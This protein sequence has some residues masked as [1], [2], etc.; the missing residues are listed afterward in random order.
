MNE[1][2]E[3]ILK[4]V[5]LFIDNIN[6]STKSTSKSLDN[7]CLKIDSV[8][9]K[10]NTPPRNEELSTQLG[11]LKTQLDGFNINLT[12]LIDM[13]KKMILVVRT[14][15]II[16]SLAVMLTGGIIEYNKYLEKK[17]LKEDM[18]ILL[19]DINKVNTKLNYHIKGVDIDKFLE[20]QKNSALKPEKPGSGQSEIVT[21]TDLNQ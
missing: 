13:I 10:I 14:G 20:K 4:V 17:I 2:G 9:T 7:L 15:V 3:S 11:D 18:K 19:S 8:K 12:V 6:E 16:L 1:N 5:N 21:P